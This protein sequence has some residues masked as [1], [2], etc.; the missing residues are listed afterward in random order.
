MTQDSDIDRVWQLMEKV[1]FCMLST[2]EDED[3][4]A[5]PMVAHP[6][7]N[8]GAIY[9]LSN[10]ESPKDEDIADDPN[11]G[12]AFA[13]TGDQNYVSI[14]GRAEISNDRQKI[15]EL[16]STAAKA[17]WNSA[18]DP[19]IRILKVTPKDAQYWDGPGST[20]SYVK[21]LEAA[22]SDSQPDI[23]DRAKVDM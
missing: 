1:R 19:S 7:R 23:G 20:A 9:F 11:V 8:E 2:H 3:I 5:R 10:V 16:W 17:W 6:E 21:M 14:S 12:L 4:R 15:E 22:A 18:D 13:D